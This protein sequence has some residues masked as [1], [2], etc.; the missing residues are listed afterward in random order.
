MKFRRQIFYFSWNEPRKIKFTHFRE[1]ISWNV[2]QTIG[3][4][5]VQAADWYWANRSFSLDGEKS[6]QFVLLSVIITLFSDHLKWK[7]KAIMAVAII[8]QNYSIWTI[9]TKNF[10]LNE[11]TNST[12]EQMKIWIKIDRFIITLGRKW[13]PQN[14]QSWAGCIMRCRKS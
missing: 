9:F 3:W 4:I 14:D 7:S 11:V 6:K 13:P 1:I 12:V 5:I 2:W 8:Y 10:A